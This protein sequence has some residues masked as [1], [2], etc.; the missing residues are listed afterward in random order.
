MIESLT[1]AGPMSAVLYAGTS[2][3]D[4]DWIMRIAREDRQGKSLPLAH[5]IIRARYRQ[6]FSEPKM[7]KP[8]EICEYRLDMW[9]AGITIDRGERLRLVVSSALFPKF[10]RDLNT[11]GHNETETDYVS[12]EQTVYHDKARPS[13]IVLPVIPDPAFAGE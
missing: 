11:G 13:H 4:T 2:A 12:A 9:Q 3:K 6:S 1:V 10:S 5:G 8:G 7:L